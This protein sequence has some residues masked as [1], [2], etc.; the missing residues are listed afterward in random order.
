MRPSRETTKRKTPRQIISFSN[1]ISHSVLA[2]LVFH[3][4]KPKT[5]IAIETDNVKTFTIRIKMSHNWPFLYFSLFFIIHV[6]NPW[7]GLFHSWWWSNQIVYW[8]EIMWWKRKLTSFYIHVFLGCF[9]G[10]ARYMLRQ[11]STTRE[12]L[13]IGINTRT[14]FKLASYTPFKLDFGKK[15]QVSSYETNIATIFLIEIFHTMKC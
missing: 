12:T 13:I 8:Y 3:I 5:N 14:N 11:K 9:L 1:R 4:L 6:L 15:L 2:C 10:Q 7:V